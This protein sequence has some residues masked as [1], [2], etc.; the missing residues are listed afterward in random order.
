MQNKYDVTDELETRLLKYN[1]VSF[2]SSHD[3]NR[4]DSSN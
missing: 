3:L 1:L 2:I 4:V